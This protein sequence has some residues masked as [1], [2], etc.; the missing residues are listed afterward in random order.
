MGCF[1]ATAQYYRFAAAD[2]ADSAFKSRAIAWVL[3]G[4]VAAAVIGPAVASWTKDIF[5]PVLFAGSYV[6]LTAMAGL[7][8]AMLSFL[9]IPVPI[10]ARGA[11]RAGR[12]LAVIARQPAFVA[13]V[14][15]NVIGYAVMAFVMTSSPLAAVACGHS[16]DAAFGIIRMHL[17]GMF[18]PS[19]FS[20]SLIKRFGLAP[21]L[22]AGSG[23]LVVSAAVAL[24]G[25]S[26]VNFWVALLLLGVGWN[27]MYVS[28]TTLLTTAYR[29]EERAK[30][31]AT[32]ELLTFGT[33]AL[34]SLA[35]GGVFGRFGW[36]GINY[37]VLPLLFAALVST[38]WYATLQRS[39][40]F[41]PAA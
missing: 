9:D 12:P 24:A 22:L 1:Q 21:V 28:G 2:A 17:V 5:A 27:F 39:G 15:N 35:A 7:A 37:T 38:L 32:N 25:T 29:P 13:G 8:V 30:A 4:G 14:A 26:L 36:S 31:Q 40:R 6:A 16:S 41:R 11:P 3:A 10:V 18:A 20:G 23:L 33:V 19:F 34:A